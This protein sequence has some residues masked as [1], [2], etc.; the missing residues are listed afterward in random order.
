[1][2][3]IK[4][5]RMG[6]KM[7]K[8]IIENFLYQGLYQITIIILPIITIPIVSHTLGVSGVGLFNYITS[9][10]SYFVLFAGLGLANYGIREIATV[11]ESIESRSKKFWELELFNIIIIICVLVIFI[12]FLNFVPN[13]IFFFVSGISIFATIFDITWFYYGTQDFKHI[14]LINIFIKLLSFFAIL[15]FINT[16]DDLLTYFFI[17]SISVL[18]SNISLWF[19]LR[20]KI[21]W[22]KPTL[23]RAF[24]HLK[25]ALHFFIG[26]ISITLYT[27]LNKTLLGFFGTTIFV[28]LYSNSLQLISMMVVLI[29]VID[30]VLMPHMTSLFVNNEEENVIRIMEHTIDLQFF[31]SIPIMFGIIATNEKIIP[32]FYGNE[33]SYLQ[34]TIP[35][36]AP[37]IVIMPLGVSIARQYLMPKNKIK[38]F[39]I[40]I[41]VAGIVSVIVNLLLIP[42]IGIWGA[43]IATVVSESI[44]TLI[45]VTDLLKNTSFKF[46]KNNILFYFLS[47]ILMY[48]CVVFFT[49]NLSASIITTCTQGIIGVVVY[50]L[51]TTIFRKNPIYEFLNQNKNRT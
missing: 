40:S 13:R 11:K 31:F 12:I 22:I 15:F 41:V 25:P 51:I 29:G 43:I 47:G 50:L 36:L 23:K 20:K 33:F 35:V 48:S 37:L 45:R 42:S 7:N 44:V 19:F 26:K 34:K 21:I 24:S 14:T 32:W 27:T 16:K 2:L 28:G 46:R 38:K 5:K 1:M 39:N 6:R 9:I 10:V 49:R 17:Q 8:K 18:F 3:F 4:A 30:T